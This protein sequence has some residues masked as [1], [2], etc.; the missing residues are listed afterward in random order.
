MEYPFISI[1]GAVH[2]KEEAVVAVSNI[3]YSY[4]FGV[5]ETI[6]ISKG[7]GEFLNDH[8]ERLMDS[9]RI[10]G[11]EHPYTSDVVG[12]S[13][14][15][16]VS[17]NSAETCNL[18]ILLIGAPKKE[19]AML[20]IV[21]L[22]PLFP[23]KKLYRDGAH[24][25]IY[26]Y[27]RAFPQAK[28]LNMLQSYL[29]YREARRAGAYDALLIA[30]DGT[31]LEGTRT[32]FFCMKGKTIVSAPEA[33]V[34]SGVMRKAV[35]KCAKEAGFELEEKDIPLSSVGE[36]DGAFLTS[37]STKIMPIRS[38]GE[39]TLGIPAELKELMVKFDTFW[40][41]LEGKL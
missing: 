32:N 22:N 33:R 13:I 17:A 35:L 20:Y 23:D 36:Y 12:K 38:V 39:I 15:E 40:D 30:R 26:E 1:N 27:E 41:G 21:C 34:L 37:T 4:G 28:T 5:Y 14:D 18:K 10:I 2:P 16:L 24:T 11:L 3:E 29:A 31:I 7:R 9:A 8:L 19:D 6:R 25:V